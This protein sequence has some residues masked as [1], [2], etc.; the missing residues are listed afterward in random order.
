MDDEA[1]PGPFGGKS[2][3]E[4]NTGGLGPAISNAV[5]DACGVRLTQLPITAERVLA[6]LSAGNGH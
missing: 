3:G 4:L 5:F 6:L 1:G 2:A